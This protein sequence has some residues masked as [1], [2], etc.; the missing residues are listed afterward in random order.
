[1]GYRYSTFEKRDYLQR[2]KFILLH[3]QV[4]ID[5][6]QKI[7]YHD[8]MVTDIEK[9]EEDGKFYQKYDVYFRS[10]GMD[11]N[12]VEFINYRINDYMNFRKQEVI[13]IIKTVVS[14]GSELQR[15]N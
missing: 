6:L 15:V 10:E 12:L 3:K 13:E 9:K 5:G 8:S 7:E 1:M 11:L 14:V 2:L 4:R